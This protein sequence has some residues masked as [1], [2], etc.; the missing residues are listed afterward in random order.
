[1]SSK[2]KPRNPFLPGA[3]L[4]NHG[5]VSERRVAKKI[6]AKPR[7]GSGAVEGFKGDSHLLLG[8]GAGILFESKCTIHQ[9]LSVKKEWLDKIREEA[10][11]EGKYPALTVSFVDQY[12]RPQDGN[13]DWVMFPQYL[14]KELL[15]L[16]EKGHA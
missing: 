16:L 11:S 12:G 13:S 6:G 7:A 14:A 8:S 5:R 4:E 15:S 1:M 3:E 10:L 9:S 2:K